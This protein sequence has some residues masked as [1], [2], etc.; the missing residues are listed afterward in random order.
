MKVN[1]KISIFPGQE[2]EGVAYKSLKQ[3]NGQMWKHLQLA[4]QVVHL[5]VGNSS[6]SHPPS[7]KSFKHRLMSTFVPW[8]KYTFALFVGK[9]VQQIETGSHLAG[10][11]FLNMK[12]TL[13]AI[14]LLV[15]SVFSLGS[16]SLIWIILC[17]SRVSQVALV[18]KNLP[19][20]AG[21][22][23]DSGSIPGLGRSPWRQPTPVF[24]PGKFHGQ[25][26]LAG[27]TSWVHIFQSNG[28]FP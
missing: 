15:S 6:Y 22:A 27:Y 28:E 16:C 17:I 4:L 2:H 26:S 7:C 3:D 12:T 25:S 14:C 24:L 10:G 13:Q 19:A 21:N 20:N 5:Q 18:V 11:C 9:A 23:R 8:L 1:F